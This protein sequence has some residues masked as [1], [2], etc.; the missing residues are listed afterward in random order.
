MIERDRVPLAVPSQLA[1]QEIKTE[2][3]D[4]AKNCREK[5]TELILILVALN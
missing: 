1:R 5:A 4:E 3:N 2:E